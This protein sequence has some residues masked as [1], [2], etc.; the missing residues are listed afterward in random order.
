MENHFLNN[1]KKINYDISSTMVI[2]LPIDMRIAAGVDGKVKLK[3][4]K[5]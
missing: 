1:L 3:N 5:H 2:H 4:T